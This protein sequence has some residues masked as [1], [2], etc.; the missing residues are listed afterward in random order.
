M[1]MCVS[2]EVAGGPPG[3]LAF[4]YHPSADVFSHGRLQQEAHERGFKLVPKDLPLHGVGHRDDGPLGGGRKERS[5]GGRHLR[6][7]ERM[8]GVSSSSTLDDFR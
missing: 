5:G 3:R 2:R 4:P 7:R 1:V 6:E 8:G